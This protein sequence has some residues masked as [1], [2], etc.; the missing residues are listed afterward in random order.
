[1]VKMEKGQETIDTTESH[2]WAE[3]RIGLKS[4]GLSWIFKITFFYF[5]A[6]FISSLLPTSNAKIPR[7]SFS[8]SF[9]YLDLEPNN[10]IADLDSYSFKSI[11]LEYPT[12]FVYFNFE[13]NKRNAA[14]LQ[15]LEVCSYHVYSR[16]LEIR[17]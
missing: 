1:M 15:T 12:V 16:F 7:N 11:I 4:M 9:G 17:N 10:D 3:T 13:D 5:L 2:S 6:L 14:I 8:N